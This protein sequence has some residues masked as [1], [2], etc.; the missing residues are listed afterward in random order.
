MSK[1]ADQ[2]LV[3]VFHPDL[4]LMDEVAAATEPEMLVPWAYHLEWLK[5][6]IGVGDPQQPRAYTNA[7]GLFVD[8]LRLVNPFGNSYRQSFMERYIRIGYPVSVFTENLRMTEG[9]EQPSSEFFYRGKLV[10]AKGNCELIYR[11]RS[12][13]F[14]EFMNTKYQLQLTT[15]RVV[16]HVARGVSIKDDTGSRFNLHNVALVFQVIQEILNK[17]LFEAEDICI[18][19]PYRAQMFLYRQTI[20]SIAS[21]ELWKR[22]R[23]LE[24]Q[25][26]TID[27]LR[28]GEAPLIILD[29]VTGSVRNT[30]QGFMTD[31]RRVNVATTRQKEATVI[32]ADVMSPQVELAKDAEDSSEAQ[33]KHEQYEQGKGKDTLMRIYERYR[34]EGSIVEIDRDKITSDIIDLQPAEDFIESRVRKCHRCQGIG[35]VAT[36]CTK[37]RPGT[38][39]VCHKCQIEG[40]VAKECPNPNAL[41]GTSGPNVPLPSVV[42]NG[43]T[44]QPSRFAARAARK[45]AI[46]FNTAQSTAKRIS[47]V[48]IAAAPTMSSSI[49][50]SK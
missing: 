22:L 35:H 10:P 38:N 3:E 31:Y 23:V 7:F 15:P 41:K 11:P 16:L 17:G 33:T 29:M 14:I 27:S 42:F 37:P 46:P 28:G 48:C 12:Q 2:L 44:A 49:A 20:D 13:A 26:R 34:H 39:V 8:G 21:T 6:I 9:L 1:A 36:D 30:G 43:K 45:K 50:Q 19:T 5:F 25:A 40:H 24:I 47:S 32:V 18:A 4:G